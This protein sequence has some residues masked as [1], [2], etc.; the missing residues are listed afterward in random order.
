MR[1]TIFI[2]GV[3][4]FL[5]HRVVFSAGFF[6]LDWY[7]EFN[8]MELDNSKWS[9]QLARGENNNV[10]WGNEE[11]QYY[12]NSASNTFVE[13]GLLTIRAKKEYYRGYNNYINRYQEADYTSAR[14]TT[15]GKY[16]TTYGRIEARISMPLGQGLWPAFWMMPERSEYGGWAASGEID[17]MEVKGRLTRQYGGT[18]HY[19]GGW[20][21]NTYATSGD[22]T[23][24]DNK[25]IEDFHVYAIEWK[26]G[27]IKWL[28]DD[29]VVYTKNA[30]NGGWWTTGGAAFPAPFNKDFHLILNFAIG[31]HFDDWRWPL[32]SWQT[33]D[34][35]IDYVRIYKWDNELTEKEMPDD[36]YVPPVKTNIALGKPATA[37]SE[38]DHP[39]NVQVPA[40]FLIASNAT[41]GV[42]DPLSR[43]GSIEVD[44]QYT[45][46]WIM[47][48]LEGIYKVNEIAILWET[49]FAKSY[50]IE[51]SVDGENWDEYYSTTAG[52]GGYGSVEND[53]T[54]RYIR[55]NCTEK[56]YNWQGNYYG[57]S[58]Y[59]VEV[60]GSASTLHKEVYVADIEL[61]QS[62][63]MILVSSQENVQSMELYSISGRLVKSQ[64]TNS[65]E[66][67]GLA[68]GIYIIKIIMVN[69]YQKTCKVII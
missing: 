66:T 2:L 58:I 12:T 43:W 33:G 69:G 11:A 45:K 52:N 25:T 30:G 63:G 26:E 21:D 46:E 65:I 59:E 44:N 57:Y 27:E 23:F 10:G 24:P 22:Y 32:D 41:D 50:S 20:P 51:T 31:G 28:C 29:V 19:G 7:D 8:G 35:K 3:C 60:Y 15:R 9:Y 61:I 62:E 38:Y 17:I 53:A 4:L 37:S 40:G 47:I 55:I 1:K 42:T 36:V 13:N 68:K 16:Y 18:I 56:G 48:D 67:I 49:A 39:G 5:S 54:A 14:I 34:M 64:T 6:K